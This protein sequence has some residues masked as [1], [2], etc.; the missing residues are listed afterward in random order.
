MRVFKIQSQ[1]TD[2]VYATR[3]DVE[4]YV[5]NSCVL[6]QQSEVTIEEVEVQPLGLRS[7]AYSRE[8]ELLATTQDNHLVKVVVV[9]GYY[10]KPGERVLIRDRS[11]EFTTRIP[12]GG[13]SLIDLIEGADGGES[14]IPWKELA[15]VSSYTEELFTKLRQP[16]HA[17]YA[18]PEIKKI[19]A[20]KTD[21]S[22]VNYWS[23]SVGYFEGYCFSLFR[24]LPSAKK[25]F[26][27]LIR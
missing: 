25:D 24:T 9:L 12:S 3:E 16:E 11:S 27:A 19:V 15:S 23:T 4:V 14:E 2:H 10:K 6:A 13:K 26:T 21:G 22:C 17:P 8:D 7:G 18:T 20:T 1:F 5:K